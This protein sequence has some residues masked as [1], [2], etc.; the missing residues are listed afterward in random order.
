MAIIIIAA[1]VRRKKLTQKNPALN[2]YLSHI[3]DKTPLNLFPMEVAK[4]HP[5]I[6]KAVKRGGLNL[7]TNERPIGL[8]NNSPMVITPYD[9]MNH[10]L[11]A[12]IWPLLHA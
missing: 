5:P 7:D 8:R 11:Y 1:A 9:P 2:S 12:F 6:I 10:Q 4:N 3:L